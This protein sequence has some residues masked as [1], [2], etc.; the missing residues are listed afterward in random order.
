MRRGRAR[1]QGDAQVQA[2]DGG[3]AF[4]HGAL[5]YATGAFPPFASPFEPERR[6]MAQEPSRISRPD[7]AQPARRPGRRLA[8]DGPRLRDHRAGGEARARG[9]PAPGPDL[10][11]REGHAV[12]GADQPAREPLA[13]G[14]RHGRGARG[15]A[16][17][18]PARDGQAH[19]AA[20]RHDR[21]V[22][23]R[24]ADRRP[25][26][27]LRPAPDPP[28][29]GRRGRLPHRR[30]LVRQGPDER[31]VELRLQPA[32]DPGARP[33]VDPPDRS[34]ST[35]GSSSASRSRSA[36]RCRWPSPSACTRP[37]RWA[38]SPSAPSTR[39]SA[40][41]WARSCASRSSW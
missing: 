5:C 2:Q 14:A 16:G 23:G 20:R 38:R 13:P 4:P 8:G 9:P 35:S 40:R 3:A 31:D 36:G 28:P 1:E 27:S 32:D 17:H 11:A 22:Q 15:H 25:H 12:P 24:G 29:R 21:P 34:A 30:D 6:D 41:S 7:Q 10:R 19:P 26:Q 39:T 37:S 33:H 18:L